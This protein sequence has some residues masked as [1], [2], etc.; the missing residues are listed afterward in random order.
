MREK[1][2]RFSLLTPDTKTPWWKGPLRFTVALAVGAVVAAKRAMDAE[3][4]SALHD[5]FC[6]PPPIGCG[7]PIGEFS[8]Y[9]FLAGWTRTGLCEFCQ[10]ADKEGG[11]SWV[12]P[13]LYSVRKQEELT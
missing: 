2:E 3:R 9:E 8:H 12:P 6:L 7:G 11:D 13:H 1:A 10:E 4:R 5:T